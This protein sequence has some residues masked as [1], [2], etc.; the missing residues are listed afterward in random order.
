ME[1]KTCTSCGETKD[2]S[3]MKLVNGGKVGAICKVCAARQQREWYHA[4]KEYL[5]IRAKAK[6]LKSFAK[7]HNV[8][9]TINMEQENGKT[10]QI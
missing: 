2:I 3:Q 1:T 5:S 4:N 8:L 9:L 10:E 6:R 7:K